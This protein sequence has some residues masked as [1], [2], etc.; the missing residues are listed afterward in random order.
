MMDRHLFAA[1]AAAAGALALLPAPAQAAAG[2]FGSAAFLSR[3]NCN[4]ATPSSACDTSTRAPEVY[5]PGGA[6]QVVD[7]SVVPSG[8][9]ILKAKVQFG[10]LDLPVIKAG[11]WSGADTRVGSTIVTYMHYKY[12]GASATP[13]ALDGLVDWTTSGAPRAAA[14]EVGSFAG[15]GSGVALLWMLDAA[16]VPKF[17]NAGQITSFPP[18]VGFGCGGAGVLGFGQLNMAKATAGY[19]EGSIALNTACGG[20]ALTLNPGQEF[21]IMAQFQSI[22][23]RGGFLDA[24]NTIRVQLAEDLPEEVKATLREELVSARSLVPEPA[25]WAMMI[26]GFGLVGAVARRRRAVAA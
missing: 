14:G 7:I 26:A 24:T 1:S 10:Q 4:A 17:A 13:Y 19:H 9:G 3:R 6:G 8:G 12:T 22:A 2:E 23:N 20:G 18:I 15:E 21:V 16:I 5:N 25:S 11:A